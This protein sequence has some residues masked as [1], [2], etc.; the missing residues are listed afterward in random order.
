MIKLSQIR[1]QL[2]L[3]AQ[4]EYDRM[5]ERGVHPYAIASYHFDKVISTELSKHLDVTNFKKENW[6][7]L[8]EAAGFYEYEIVCDK[9]NQNVGPLSKGLWAVAAF[10][11][12]SEAWSSPGFAEAYWYHAI[13]GG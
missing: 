3:A 13:H 7:Q 1:H 12:S 4:E 11:S 2:V 10:L 5:I 6:K 8:Q 9:Y